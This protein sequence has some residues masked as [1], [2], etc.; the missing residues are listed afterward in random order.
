MTSVTTNAIVLNKGLSFAKNK[1]G[2]AK[3]EI[4][5]VKLARWSVLNY[6]NKI[7]IKK[8]IR[9]AFDVPMVTDLVGMYL[10]S[11][12][13]VSTVEIDGELCSDDALFIIRNLL[14]DN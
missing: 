2:M 4:D 8:G 14:L 7:C 3:E 10:L 1:I 6:R 5:L 12:L 11:K 9:D 13:K